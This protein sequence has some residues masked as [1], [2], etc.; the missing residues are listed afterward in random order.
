M[1]TA[2]YIPTEPLQTGDIVQLIGL[3]NRKVLPAGSMEEARDNQ[4]KRGTICIVESPERFAGDAIMV[5]V[6]DGCGY[7][8]FPPCFFTLLYKM[9]PSFMWHIVESG[10]AY[11]VRRNQPNGK[12]RTL[13]GFSK[14][15]RYAYT[16][17]RNL[18]FEMNTLL[19]EVLREYLV[20]HPEEYL[21][22][23]ART[24]S[25]VENILNNI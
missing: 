2:I 20:R 15:Y 16:H 14:T 9:N 13:A 22:D 3:P 7:P 21:H 11:V 19:R 23:E 4:K 10:N 24:K 8:E 17:A 18:M 5:E 25:I 6:Y 12:T 1:N